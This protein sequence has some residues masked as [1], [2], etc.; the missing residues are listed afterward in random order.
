MFAASSLPVLSIRTLCEVS[1]GYSSLHRLLWD[2]TAY[3]IHNGQDLS[4]II[5]P[6]GANRPGR[7]PKMPCPDGVRT[8][9][10][11]IP[12][13]I[14]PLLLHLFMV[15]CSRGRNILPDP[16]I[17]SAPGAAVLCRFAD[18]T[19]TPQ[20][21]GN[22][23]CQ[24]LCDRLPD[25]TYTPQGD[26]NL[27]VPVKAGPVGKRHNLHPARGRKPLIVELVLRKN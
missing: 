2:C 25:T 24:T 10:L 16:I 21:D 19:Y 6:F 13:Q 22:E 26:G 7:R 3:Y 20:G 27:H 1:N 17:T 23:D 14:P 8:R 9:H 4:T 12:L 5:C 11:H 15:S 18:T